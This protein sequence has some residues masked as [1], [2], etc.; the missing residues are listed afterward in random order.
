MGSESTR[1]QPGVA[2]WSPAPERLP[3]IE[4]N[5]IAGQ[6]PLPW[7]LIHVPAKLEKDVE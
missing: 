3:Q 6:T 4:S 5:G 7:H 1:A 2:A